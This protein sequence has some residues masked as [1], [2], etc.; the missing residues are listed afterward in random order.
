MR[1]F[2]TVKGTTKRLFAFLFCLFISHL[3]LGQGRTITGKVTSQNEEEALQGATIS[4][5]NSKAA[6]T[7]QANG[8]FS[9]NAPAN[10]VLV[11]S[12]VGYENKEIAVGNQSTLNVSLTSLSKALDDVV[13]IGYGTVK[14]SDVTGSVVSIKA[15]ELTQGAN[16]NVQ[17]M[18]EGR[19]SGVQIT[20]STG[21]PGS[22]MSV[23]IRGVT[24]ITAGNDPL[25]VI[26]GMPVNDG[27]P[28]TGVGAFF[29]S[30]PPRNPLNSLN[31]ADIASIEIL[32]DASATAIYGSRGANGVVL[33][34]T[35]SGSANKLTINW[36]SYYGI[37]KVAR[38]E[39]ISLQHNTMI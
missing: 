19:A 39:K 34:T 27:A 28:V 5:K 4:I 6:T 30:Q 7:T 14:K 10:A 13:V 36:N 25:Y 23:K 32:K 29:A 11:V 31:P 17:Q 21:E 38:Q 24:S 2:K 15:S 16:I 3:L 35:K 12:M 22:A 33:I 20:R 26:D 37:Q 1:R 8:T 18:L 9:I